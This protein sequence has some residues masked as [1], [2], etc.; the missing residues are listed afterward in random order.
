MAPA[1][2]AAKIIDG[3][4]LKGVNEISDHTLKSMII[5]ST[6]ADELSR[7]LSQLGH[8]Y[9]N[10]TLSLITCVQKQGD[11]MEITGS[12][13]QML[14]ILIIHSHLQVPDLSI[15]ISGDLL[16]ARFY[17]NEIWPAAAQAGGTYVDFD[18]RGEELAFPSDRS[19]R[20]YSSWVNGQ[21]SDLVRVLDENFQEV[22]LWNSSGC[23]LRAVAAVYIC[24]VA[25]SLPTLTSMCGAQNSDFSGNDIPTTVLPIG[26]ILGREVPLVP[27]ENSQNPSGF[28]FLPRILW[29][30]PGN[31]PHRSINRADLLYEQR[32]VLRT[33]GF[34][35][36]LSFPKWEESFFFA[37]DNPAPWPSTKKDPPFI[38][39]KPPSGRPAAVHDDKSIR[40]EGIIMMGCK[41]IIS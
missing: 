7:N 1:L 28:G 12:H 29:R 6:G 30:D 21:T 36:F 15:H 32:S 11:S 17:T 22:D 2:D 13:F 16:K 26:D 4:L 18:I 41:E 19:P 14:G 3:D 24:F 35:K 34:S 33:I 40:Q 25:V 10:P 5:K 38:W 23:A 27:M 20:N 8:E 39:P 9:G 37:T 31:L